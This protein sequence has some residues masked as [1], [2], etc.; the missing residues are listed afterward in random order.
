MSHIRDIDVQ[1]ILTVLSYDPETGA[2]VRNADQSPIGSKTA[3]GYLRIGVA[4]GYVLAH[5]L[6][7]AIVHGGAPMMIDHINGVRS[8]NRICNL[9][10]ANHAINSQNIVRPNSNSLSGSRGVTWSARHKKYRARIRVN[11]ELRDL[12]YYADIDSASRAYVEAKKAHHPGFVER[13]H[14]A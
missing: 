9:R 8:D 12:G 7:Y 10:A 2:F 3:H 13:A 5:R 14:V 1:S 6:A 4:G 11:G